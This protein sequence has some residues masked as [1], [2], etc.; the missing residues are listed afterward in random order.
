MDNQNNLTPTEPEP[1]QTSYQPQ[2]QQMAPQA[3]IEQPPVA[4]TPFTAPVP[5]TPK[6]SKKKLIIIIVIILLLGVSGTVIYLNFLKPQSILNPEVND[7]KVSYSAIDQA[8]IVAKKD[9]K[10][11]E[12]AIFGD[13]KVKYNSIKH[14]MPDTEYYQAG[15][16][17]ELVAINLNLSNADN[18]SK[19]T[20][21]KRDFE[22]YYNNSSTPTP[23]VDII[24]AN[25]TVY[26]D[27]NLNGD[28]VFEVS[29]YATSLKLQYTTTIYTET[30][31]YGEQ[32]LAYTLE[33]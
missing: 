13:L 2:S 21:K 10:K 22:L 1:T 18:S 5:E 32:S 30:S 9:F 29:K 16:G 17:K 12:M 24:F 28:I 23:A 19:V 25:D 11:G 26:D 4:Q 7:N 15:T 20:F 6:K 31:D 27:Q 14:N 3:P 33:I 8:K